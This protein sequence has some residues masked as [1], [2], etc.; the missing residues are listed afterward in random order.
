MPSTLT[1]LEARV[2]ALLY[3]SGNSIFTVATI[4]EALKQARDLYTDA[5]PCPMETLLTLPGDG[6]EIALNGVSNLIAVTEVWFPYDS[7]ETQE[8]W[9]RRKPRGFR[10]R[11]DDTQP[12]LFLNDE[13]GS[14]PQA[15]EE[16]YLFYT[17]PH[18]IQNLDAAST[19]T[20]PSQHESHLCRGAAGFCALT[21][22]V[23]LSETAANMAVS[24]PNL[25]ALANL[26]LN[27]PYFGYL[28]FLDTL[29]SR[30]QISGDPFASGWRMDKHDRRENG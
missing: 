18:T 24:T 29:R 1:Q 17:V 2:A 22:S 4:D 12:V 23:D 26:Y 9:T 19:T 30:S 5:A 11:R 6:R 14:E 3:D 27:D 10:V 7:T 21:R 15:D 8:T 28:P 20:I 13:L 16:L 25:A